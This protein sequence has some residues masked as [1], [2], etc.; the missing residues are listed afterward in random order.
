MLSLMS[1]PELIIPRPFHK[2]LGRGKKEGRI[3]IPL[4]TKDSSLPAVSDTLFPVILGSY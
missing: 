4:S 2:E 1:R 3:K